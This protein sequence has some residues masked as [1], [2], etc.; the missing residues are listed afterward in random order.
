MARDV[1]KY[2][3]SDEA[4]AALGAFGGGSGPTRSKLDVTIGT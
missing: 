3:A 1:S 2:P 4:T